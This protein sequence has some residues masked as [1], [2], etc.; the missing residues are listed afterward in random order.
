MKMILLIVLKSDVFEVKEE[1]NMYTEYLV[2]LSEE[3]VDSITYNALCD[4]TSCHCD[5]IGGGC[6]CITD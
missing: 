1:L 6:D 5:C 3:N 4:S 2:N